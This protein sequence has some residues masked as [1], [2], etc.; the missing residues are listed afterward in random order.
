[1]AGKPLDLESLLA[2][3]EQAMRICIQ[4]TA[5][6]EGLESLLIDKGLVTR[7]AL[8]AKIRECQEMNQKFSGALGSL[9]S[10]SDS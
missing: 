9:R 5:R 6:S 4:T 10:E 8:D 1:M 2:L 7:E 3:V